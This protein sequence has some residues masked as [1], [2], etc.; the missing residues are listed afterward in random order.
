M[1]S[2]LCFAQIKSKDRLRSDGVHPT[3]AVADAA[4][5]LKKDG[6]R[7][8]GETTLLSFFQ[9]AGMVNHHSA[10]CFVFPEAEEEYNN[11]IKVIQ[12]Q[13]GSEATKPKRPRNS[14]TKQ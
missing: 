7:W 6:F 8:L 1:C 9:A 4:Q 12:A 3:A 11:A 5:T 13:T 2:V 14:G 10:D